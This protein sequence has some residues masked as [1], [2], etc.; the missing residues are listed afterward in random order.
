MALFNDSS[1]KKKHTRKI[2]KLQYGSAAKASATLKR[3]HKLPL[4]KQ[5]FYARSMYYRAK[6]NKNQT[7]GMREAMK[8]YSKFLS[9]SG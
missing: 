1:Q 8:V 2:P 9:Q 4:H 3:L 6:H 5:R 7:K